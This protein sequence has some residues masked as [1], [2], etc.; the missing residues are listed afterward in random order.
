MSHNTFSIFAPAK[1]NLFLHITGKR[2]DGYHTLQ[3]LMAFADVGDELEFLAQKNFQIEAK[4]PFADALPVSEDN[5]VYKAARLLS[6][7]YKTPLQG[8]IILTK[9]LPVASGIGGGS[10]DAAAALKGLAKLWSLPDEPARLQKIALQLGADVPACFYST[11]GNGMVWAEGAGEVLIPVP[12]MPAV[13]FVLVNPMIPTAT[14][15][16][17]KNFRGGSSSPIKM[18]SMNAADLKKCRNDLTEAA[19]LVTPEIK[20]V[21]AA[22]VNTENCLLHRLSGSGATCFGLYG[23]ATIAQTAAQTLKLHRPDWW[24][25]AAN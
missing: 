2:A 5:L 13:H 25:T 9:N 12:D 22:I 3:S 17:F 15:A 20:D 19:L 10:A 16:V 1:I 4:G 23:N 14:A 24:I 6:E 18:Q 7:E 8:K 11:T 21:L